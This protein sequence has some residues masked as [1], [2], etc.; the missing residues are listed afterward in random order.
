VTVEI[1]LMAPGALMT[2]TF[3]CGAFAG[4]SGAVLATN[5]E[6]MRDALISVES[7]FM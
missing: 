1:P 3:G 6:A 5:E 2:A 4:A 7:T